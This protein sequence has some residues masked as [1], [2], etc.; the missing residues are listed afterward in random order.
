MDFKRGLW[1]RS[2]CICMQDFR[3]GTTGKGKGKLHVRKPLVR[4]GGVLGNGVAMK[5]QRDRS[6]REVGKARLILDGRDADHVLRPL[7]CHRSTHQFRWSHTPYTICQQHAPNLSVSQ[8]HLTSLVTAGPP[9]ATFEKY[10][11]PH[12]SPLPFL[13]PHCPHPHP[14]PHPHPSAPCYP[15]APCPDPLLSSRC[16]SPS[17]FSSPLP[18]PSP[19][20]LPSSQR[21]S[22]HRPINI[23]PPIPPLPRNN[24]PL[25]LH[26]SL[27]TPPSS[28]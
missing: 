25:P 4:E 14:H 24:N 10:K 19:P 5:G 7:C 16:S 28:K 6:M 2:G 8:L 18:S 13:T 9:M 17:P 22:L 12:F 27:T 21:M 15:T 3:S 23:P 11:T 20:S 26:P 1:W